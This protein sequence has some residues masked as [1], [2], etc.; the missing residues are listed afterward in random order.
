M[1]TSQSELE[2]RPLSKERNPGLFGNTAVH[3]WERGQG[4]RKNGEVKC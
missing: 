3:L 1:E 4:W 2:A